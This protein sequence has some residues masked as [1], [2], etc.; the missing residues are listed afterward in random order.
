[1]E[2]QKNIELF[3]N[4]IRFEKRYSEHTAVSYEND[5][6]QFARYMEEQFE[7]PD[8]RKTKHLHVRS[9]IVALMEE[10]LSPKSIN[11]KISTLRSFFNFMR[12]KQKIEVSP[13]QKIIAPK[14]GKRLPKHLTEENMIDLH[15]EIDMEQSFTSVRNRL[16]IQ[17]FYNTGIR[18][19]ELIELTEA[20]T[21]TRN[22][23]I[24]VLGKGNKERQIPIPSSLSQQIEQYR[25]L[26]TAEFETIEADTLI[27]TDKGKKL[28]PRFVYNIVQ[29]FIAKVSTIDQKSP[30][31]LRHTFATH[32]INNGAELNAIKE[33][34]GHANLSATQ[35]YTHNSISR[36]KDIYKKAHPSSK[37][38]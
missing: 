14:V 4:F 9:W 22:H 27:V 17:L 30:H 29:R 7:Q 3:L 28:Y 1:M 19:S 16:I 26:K 33:L 10:N 31:V 6:G 24:K 5:L 32:L 23:Y 35:I 13:M 37:A 18:R 8:L 34:L 36:L 15:E 20:N 25:A 2:I 12:K 21:D 11:R 38:Q